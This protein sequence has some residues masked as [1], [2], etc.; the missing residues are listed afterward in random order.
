MSELEDIVKGFK[1][2]KNIVVTG[3]QRSG[4]QIA[5]RIIADILNWDFVGEQTLF[6]KGFKHSDCYFKWVNNTEMKTMV[7]Q[8]PSISHEC[9]LTP[10]PTLVVFMMREV[11]EIVASDKHRTDTFTTISPNNGKVV[12]VKSVFIQKGKQYAKLFYDRERSSIE[13]VPQRVYDV[14]N[15][16]QKKADFSWYELEYNKLE[17]HQFWLSLSVRRSMFKS[18]TQ[19][20]L[21]EEG[22]K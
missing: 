22:D 13:E 18:G 7:L 6:V 10:K 17:Q 16:V 15:N 8:C 14:W 20:K 21:L 2:Y 12:N 5:A 4:T 3:P 9:H 11:E 1:E 19:T